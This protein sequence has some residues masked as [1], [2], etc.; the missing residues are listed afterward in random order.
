MADATPAGV[1]PGG[2]ASR[3][4]GQALSPGPA[5]ALWGVGFLAVFCSPCLRTR[6]G[7][8]ARK[9][10]RGR[11]RGA[12]EIGVR[13][14][15]LRPSDSDAHPDFGISLLGGEHVVTSSFPPGPSLPVRPL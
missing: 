7:A 10:V 2:G 5:P 15:L 4:R 9:R 12:A 11:G 6:A 3:P 13:L 14:D 8:G 1:R